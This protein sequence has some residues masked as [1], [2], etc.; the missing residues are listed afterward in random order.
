MYWTPLL[1]YQ[2]ANGSFTDVHNDGTLVYYE[3][4]GDDVNHTVAFPPGFRVV[5]GTST[6]RAYNS[7][8]TTYSDAKHKSR[9][10]A[11]RVSFNCINPDGTAQTAGIENTN[12]KGEY[13]IWR[14]I[15][16]HDLIQS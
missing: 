3:G 5:S 11:D 10:V 13:H 15:T 14:S 8:D 12:C 6:L 4:R 7:N 16:S 9:P 2:Y 1:Y